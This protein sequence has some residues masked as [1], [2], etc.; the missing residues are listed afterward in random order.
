MCLYY[1]KA[2]VLHKDGQAA[3]EQI[4]H[5]NVGNIIGVNIRLVLHF[6]KV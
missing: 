5:S 1:I 6:E 4:P 3:F 2:D